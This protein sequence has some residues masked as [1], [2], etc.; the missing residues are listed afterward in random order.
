MRIIFCIFLNVRKLNTGRSGLPYEFIEQVSNRIINEIAAVSSGAH[1]E[2]LGLLQDL[3]DTHFSSEE[4][5]ENDGENRKD[6]ESRRD[7]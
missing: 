7:I 4:E 5:E 6:A 1:L 2:D 3:I